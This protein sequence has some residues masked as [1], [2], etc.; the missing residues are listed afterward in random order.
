MTNAI[1]PGCVHLNHL[2]STPLVRYRRSQMAHK[3]FSSQVH[4]PTVYPASCR[5]MKGQNKFLHYGGRDMTRAFSENNPAIGNFRGRVTSFRQN[6]KPLITQGNPHFLRISRRNF[7]KI[8]KKLEHDEIKEEFPFYETK[9][10][11]IVT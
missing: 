2:N 11:K 3:T 1:H 7:V 6:S 8:K 9:T 10:R 5:L 4:R